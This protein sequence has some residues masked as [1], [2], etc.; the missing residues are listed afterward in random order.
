[1]KKFIA[2]FPGQQ[3]PNISC[4]DIL[5]GIGAVLLMSIAT[6]S[7]MIMLVVL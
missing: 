1:M 2:K 5:K 6:F 3:P 7:I 4:I